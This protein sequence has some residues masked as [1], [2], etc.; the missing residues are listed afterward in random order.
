M[1]VIED[2]AEAIK[3]KTS[4]K[5]PRVPNG[6]GLTVSVCVRRSCWSCRCCCWWWWWNWLNQKK[7]GIWLDGKD[8]Q[9]LLSCEFSFLH[10]ILLYHLLNPVQSTL[11]G[12][13]KCMDVKHIYFLLNQKSPAEQKLSLYKWTNQPTKRRHLHLEHIRTKTLNI[14]TYIIRDHSLQ[15]IHFGFPTPSLIPAKEPP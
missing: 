13:T 4:R 5:K 7:G 9:L 12:I 15:T 2:V 8:N 1:P 11:K 6:M 14:Y 3:P 10:F